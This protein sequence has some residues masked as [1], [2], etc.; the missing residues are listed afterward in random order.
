MRYKKLFALLLAL[1]LV[2]GSLSGCAS[3]RQTAP[4][5]PTV[6]FTDSLGRTV[7]IPETLTRVAPSGTVAS[8]FLATNAPEYMTTI[9]ATPSSSQYKYLD[10]RLIDLPTTGQM[11]GSKSTLNLESI[12]TSGV[13][14]VID[15]GD[16]KDNMA[17][18]LDA[19][20]AA[21]YFLSIPNPYFVYRMK[22]L[23]R[24]DPARTLVELAMRGLQSAG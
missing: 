23:G 3:E 6:S 8:M 16:K 15:L 2:C 12:L 19:P 18:D 1:A 13:Q 14:V 24:E 5:E 20:A 4:A 10:P 9:N 7:D 22:M 17:A 11:Y 21:A